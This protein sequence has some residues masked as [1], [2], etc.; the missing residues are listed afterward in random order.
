MYIAYTTAPTANAG[1][2]QT[3]CANNAAVTLNGSVTLATGGRWTTSGTG[4]FSPSD[5]TLNATYNPSAADK[6]AGSIMLFLN[7]TGNGNCNAAKDT[8]VVTLTPAPVANAGADKV[9]CS[10]NRNVPLNGSVTNATG[11][12]WSTNGTGTFTPNDSTLNT[13]Y[14]YSSADSAAGT[15]R[16]ILTTLGNGSCVA[17]K[18][19][20]MLTITA[21]PITNAGSDQTVCANN[22]NI[23]LNGSVVSSAGTGTWSSTGNG[24]FTPSN[25]AFNA[26]YHPGSADVAAG[27][28]TLILTPSNAC[29][30][31]PDSMHAVITP[32]P[33]VNAGTDIFICNASSPASLNGSVT[34]GANKG[35][36]TTS[37]SGTFSPN[38]STLNAAYH[39]SVSD[40]L[41]GTVNLVLTSTNNGSCQAV[42]DTVKITMSTAAT[43]NAGNDTTVCANVTGIQ[44]NGTVTGGSGYRTM[45]YKRRGYLHGFVYGTQRFYHPVAADISAGSVK[46]FL[47]ST[48]ACQN[49]VDTMILSFSA[50]PSANAGADKTICAGDSV[51]LG[52]SVTNATGGQWSSTGSGGVPSEHHHA[53]CLLYSF[54]ERHFSRI[55]NADP[56]YDR[57]YELYVSFGCPDCL[58][59]SRPFR[60]GRK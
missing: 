23:Q 22:S 49:S 6:V 36:W 59:R 26:V 20:L 17:V 52:G 27:Q 50:I 48:L 5:S 45:D 40:S 18:D 58:I 31:I 14:V 57:K 30:S 2:N 46:L 19:T 43:A 25:S 41:S 32:A 10:T 56:Y 28:V 3:V 16:L 21:A 55:R 8:L 24:T 37:G 42:T 34:A 7:T 60:T 12:R 51:G 1:S 39:F 53:Q 11:G 54:C 15:V 35:R 4:T 13:T 33:A 29:T 44:L 47:A 38:D 9:A